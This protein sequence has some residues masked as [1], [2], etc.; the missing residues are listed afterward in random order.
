MIAG[1]GG[2]EKRERYSRTKEDRKVYRK[3]HKKNETKT[4]NRRSVR[5]S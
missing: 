3:R 1:G 4:T 5:K 2:R